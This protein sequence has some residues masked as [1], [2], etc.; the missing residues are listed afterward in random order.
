MAEQAVERTKSSL[1]SELYGKVLLGAY[2]KGDAI[3]LK[4]YLLEDDN[5]DYLLK[6]LR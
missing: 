6:L 4:A 2:E 3:Y 5:R 1:P